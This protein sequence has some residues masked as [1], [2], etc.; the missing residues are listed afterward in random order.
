MRTILSR[1]VGLALAAIITIPANAA[2]PWPTRPVRIVVPYGPGGTADFFG[3]IAA[4]QLTKAFGQQFVVENRA[5][6]GGLVGSEFVAHAA[7]DGYTLEISG[8]ASH[9]MAPALHKDLS[10]DPINDFTHIVLL[11]GPPDVIAVNK[12][13]RT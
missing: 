10:F 11:G 7:A 2:E 4:D 3:R 6:A 13:V 9:I 12:A 8:V 1:L 5:G